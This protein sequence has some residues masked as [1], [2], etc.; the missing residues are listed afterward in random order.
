MEENITD[1]FFPA[2]GTTSVAFSIFPGV[3]THRSSS[4][5]SVP[6]DDGGGRGGGG[7]HEKDRKVPEKPDSALRWPVSSN[8]MRSDVVESHSEMLT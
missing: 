1:F 3:D 4:T 8:S 6:D 2:K 7:A 5:T